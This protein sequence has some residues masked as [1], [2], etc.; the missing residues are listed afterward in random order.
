MAPERLPKRSPPSTLTTVVVFLPVLFID[1]IAAQLFSDQA[2]TVTGSLLASLLVSLTIIPMMSARARRVI[3][4]SVPRRSFP[5]RAVSRLIQGFRNIARGL[6]GLGW[7]LSRPVD[8]AFRFSFGRLERAYPTIIRGG[9]RFPGLVAVTA[10]LFTIGSLYTASNLPLELI[11]P[12]HQG[13]FLVRLEAPDGTGLSRTAE[14]SGELEEALAASPAVASVFAS[15]GTAERQQAAGSGGAQ[16]EAEI[17]VVMK[18][19]ADR[20]AEADVIELA[21]G[22]AS[23]IPGLLYRIDRPGS[24]T[25]RSPL[26]VEIYGDEISGLTQVAQDLS[27]RLAGLSFLTDVETDARTGNPEI[28]IHF[29]RER[30]QR[31]GLEPHLVATALRSRLHGE[32]A[33]R[34]Q[35]G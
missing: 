4:A 13:E 6:L 10:L 23:D 8:W 25:L 12:M 1:G 32:V 20:A 14:L 24:F 27:D 35:G 18:N 21:R 3:A 11:P 7:V 17:H 2:M 33:T 9:L 28:Q 15:I 19:R 29:D 26:E 34:I 5:F 30:L 22:I 31:L 16:N